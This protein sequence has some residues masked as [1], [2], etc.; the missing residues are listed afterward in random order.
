M[1]FSSIKET[2]SLASKE[3]WNIYLNVTILSLRVTI[4]SVETFEKWMCLITSNS[5]YFI[6]M[7]HWWKF[8]EKKCKKLVKS[9]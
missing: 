1:F 8:S 9:L 7:D 3:L 2:N 5:L 6:E 4:V